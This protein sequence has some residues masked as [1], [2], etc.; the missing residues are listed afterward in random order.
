MNGLHVGQF[1]LPPQPGFNSQQRLS[2]R[3]TYGLQS[4]LI[5]DDRRNRDDSISVGVLSL[6]LS[7]ALSLALAL[8][9]VYC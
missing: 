2:L 3:A 9:L 5:H 8:A 4:Q 6:V 1:L 7:L